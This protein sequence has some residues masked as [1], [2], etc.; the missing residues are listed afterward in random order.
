LA[1]A[2]D[3]T[4]APVVVVPPYARLMAVL[5][6]LAG[7]ACAVYA[8]QIRTSVDTDSVVR[9]QEP[10]KVVKARAGAKKKAVAR[11]ATKAKRKKGA[12]RKKT[13]PTGATK[14]TLATP[15]TK[16]T[17]K[18]QDTKR[19]I[20]AKRTSDT[21]FNTLIGIAAALILLGAFYSR[22]SKVTVAG[23]SIELTPLPDPKTAQEDAQ[24]LA[25]EISKQLNEELA[26]RNISPQEMTPEQ[27]AE[28]T[29]RAALAAAHAQQEVLAVRVAAHRV[30]PTAMLASSTPIT[31]AS[32]QLQNIEVGESLPPALLARLAQRAVKQNLEDNPLPKEGGESAPESG[33][34]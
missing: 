9:V 10:P 4:T 28:L 20:T 34:Q 32:E 5:L 26:K 8:T 3:T 23:N 18:L 31:V 15:T 25:A 27:T 17:P 7:I 24:K 29:T 6:V 19:T 11:H 30:R 16:A 22:V 21:T 1:T 33:N 12:K 2:A 14:K 13:G